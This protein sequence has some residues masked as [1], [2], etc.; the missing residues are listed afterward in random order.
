MAVSL[1]AFIAAARFC[2]K[3][4]GRHPCSPPSPDSTCQGVHY[5]SLVFEGAAHDEAAWSK[6]L[7]V[8]L[9]FLYAARQPGWLHAML[10]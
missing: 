7:H 2:E 4:A 8:P 10:V 9:A 1:A 6:R 3:Y 5:A